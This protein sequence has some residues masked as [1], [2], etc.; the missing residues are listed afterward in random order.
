MLLST[1]NSKS[2][3]Y[4]LA[5]QGLLFFLLDGLYTPICQRSGGLNITRLDPVTESVP[6]G[7]ISAYFENSV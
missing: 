5:D 6:N 7:P 2:A 3:V 1:A 4:D